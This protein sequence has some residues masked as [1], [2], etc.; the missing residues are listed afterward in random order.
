M[1]TEAQ[2]ID[3]REGAVAD[4]AKRTI[5]SITIQPKDRRPFVLR[6]WS[7]TALEGIWSLDIASFGAYCWR[8][9]SKEKLVAKGV[10]K[11]QR[12]ALRRGADSPLI[13]VTDAASGLKVWIPAG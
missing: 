2:L 11:L 12:R 1:S 6:R 10:K 9:R 13:I 5:A 3:G 4:L 7:A 8:A